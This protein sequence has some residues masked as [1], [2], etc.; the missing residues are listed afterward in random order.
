MRELGNMMEK[1][2]NHELIGTHER[3][4]MKKTKS[5]KQQKNAKGA[6]WHGVGGYSAM[7]LC[8]LFI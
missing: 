2:R 8:V 3:E 5:H 4:E 1:Q 7:A 6:M